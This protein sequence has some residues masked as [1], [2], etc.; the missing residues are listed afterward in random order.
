MHEKIKR[1]QLAPFQAMVPRHA[2]A[3]HAATKTGHGHNHKSPS[4][5]RASFLRFFQGPEG[6]RAWV[7]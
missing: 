3:P 2:I 7:A 4:T 1:L 5:I 6:G